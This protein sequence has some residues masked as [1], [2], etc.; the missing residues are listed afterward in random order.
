MLRKFIA[1]INGSC[2]VLQATDHT[3]ARRLA[4]RSFRMVSPDG[5]LPFNKNSLDIAIID[6]EAAGYSPDSVDVDAMLK[7]ER[8]HTVP[9][10]ETQHDMLYDDWSRPTSAQVDALNAEINEVIKEQDPTVLK[11]WAKSNPTVVDDHLP[12]E[13][14]VWAQIPDDILNASHEAWLR[15]DRRKDTR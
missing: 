3:V 1:T 9:W 15:T 12:N 7:R 5:T 13:A 14:T 6:V 11:A 4:N 10:C 8:L 2:R